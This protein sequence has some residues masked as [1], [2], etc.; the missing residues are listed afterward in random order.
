MVAIELT[1]EQAELLKVMIAKKI[2]GTK[3]VLENKA[4]KNA[5]KL[6]K[7]IGVQQDILKKLGVEPEKEEE[8]KGDDSTEME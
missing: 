7:N 5:D 4:P 8:T 2:E 3:W 1:D 6:Q